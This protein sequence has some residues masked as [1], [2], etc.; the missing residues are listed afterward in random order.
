M[1]TKIRHKLRNIFI[2]GLLTILPIFITYFM[3]AFL[4]KKVDNLSQPLVQ[5]LLDFL[6][7]TGYQGIYIP[8]LG[9]TLTILIVFFTG[10]VVTNI[11]GSKLMEF[12]ENLLNKIP[13]VNSIY[14]ASKQFLYAISLSS[15]DSFSKVVL[16]E[17]PRKGVYSIGF[18]TCTTTGEPQR[19]TEKE[20]INI[21]IPTTPNPTSGMLIMVPK[22]DII[23]LSM[24][25]EEGI[26][27]VVSG[28]MVTPLNNR[29]KHNHKK[30]A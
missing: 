18:I 23:P 19:F 21:F 2:A 16:V 13:L 26:K 3:L 24:T 29:L 30:N 1:W 20:L 12:G 17:Y 22:D 27:L 5:R 14:G 4:F 11:I 6:S 9:I 8:G 28:G 15:Q 25:V 10:L 7:F